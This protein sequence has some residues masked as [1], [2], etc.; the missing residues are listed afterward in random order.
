MNRIEREIK[1]CMKAKTEEQAKQVAGKDEAVVMGNSGVY[2][3]LPFKVAVALIKDGYEG[4][5]QGL[6]GWKSF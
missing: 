5:F 3:V 2:W 4:F 1:N 6:G